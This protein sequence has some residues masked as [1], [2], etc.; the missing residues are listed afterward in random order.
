MRNKDSSEIVDAAKARIPGHYGKIMEWC[1]IDLESF[2]QSKRAQLKKQVNHWYGKFMIV[3]AENNQLRKK[4][5]RICN[6]LIAYHDT[7]VELQREVE[8]K[9]EEIS[10]LQAD[11]GLA[12]KEWDKKDTEIRDLKLKVKELEE[13]L[14]KARL[15]FNEQSQGVMA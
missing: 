9:Q 13:L 7:E 2:Y 10:C 4:E 12:I 6:T 1:Y 5:R 11:A 8:K 15:R 3:K 14:T